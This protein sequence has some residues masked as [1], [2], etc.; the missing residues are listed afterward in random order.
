LNETSI[1]KAKL[2]AAFAEFSWQ[3]R[4]RMDTLHE[5]ASFLGFWTPS[6]TSIIDTMAI[7]KKKWKLLAVLMIIMKLS[8]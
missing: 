6:L 1:H 8:Y 2:H 3:N 4:K 7:T 5:A